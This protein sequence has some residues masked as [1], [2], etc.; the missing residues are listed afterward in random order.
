MEQSLNDEVTIGS[1]CIVAAG[2]VVIE[3]TDIS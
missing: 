2:S 3:G 1:H